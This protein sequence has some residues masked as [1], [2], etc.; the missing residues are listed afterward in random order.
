MKNI[1]QI[2]NVLLAAAL[3]IL[4]IKI[5]L[6]DNGKSQVETKAETADALDVIMTRASVRSYTDQPVEKD[7]VEKMLKAAMAAPTARNQQPWAFVVVDS[8]EILDELAETLPHAKMAAQAPLAIVACGDL[9]KSLSGIAQEYWVQD[10]SAAI[11]NLLLAAH[12]MELGAVWTG[13]YPIPERV[14]D[15]VQVLSLPEHIIP[16]AVIPIGYPAGEVQPKDK[17]KPENVRYN[18]WE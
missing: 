9:T 3:V 10:V 14:N 8:R 7:K 13:V 12:A 2:L 1:S 6:L 11:E 17:W 16:L 5:T 15:V 18:K 4:A